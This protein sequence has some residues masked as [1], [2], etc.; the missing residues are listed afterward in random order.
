MG[1]VC[2]RHCAEPHQLPFGLTAPRR[3]GDLRRQQLQ[4]HQ[5]V[6][7]LEARLQGPER[8]QGL[9]RRGQDPDRVQ[10]DRR[11]ADRAKQIV[12]AAPVPPGRAFD[13]T[14]LTRLSRFHIDDIAAWSHPTAGCDFRHFV[15]EPICQ[16]AV[17]LFRSFL[18]QLQ[19]F[20]KRTRQFNRRL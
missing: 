9:G 4:R 13:V 7:D 16:V 19:Q 6:R 11:L 20:S 1:S 8:V 17:L 3:A 18:L 14:S 2:G 12:L 15:L 10:G 5:R